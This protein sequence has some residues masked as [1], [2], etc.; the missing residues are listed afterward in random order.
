MRVAIPCS[1]DRQH[2]QWLA[3]GQRTPPPVYYPVPRPNE[4][5]TPCTPSHKRGRPSE[6]ENIEPNTDDE[7]LRTPLSP[8]KGRRSTK[9]QK[10]SEELTLREK[11][12]ICF[13]AIIEG[14]GLSF[15]EFLYY[16]FRFEDE[17]HVLCVRHFLQGTAPGAINFT[18]A[19]LVDILLRHP[20]G[21]KRGKDLAHEADLL[22]STTMDWKDIKS[23]LTA[24][25]NTA[26]KA[27]NGLHAMR[28]KRRAGAAGAANSPQIED[29]T[30]ADIGSATNI[31]HS[32]GPTSL[33][34][35]SVHV[36]VVAV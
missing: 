12:D 9:K 31:S 34:S 30:W 29:I 2:Q 8:S 27:E 5:P 24:E 1:M 10:V 17:R 14:A 36:R 18:P 7:D 21:R 28:Y 4:S 3:A 32:H 19:M 13:A 20:Y 16:A 15:G 23:V 6:M 35:R 26:V 22:Y 33:P 25:A 11:L